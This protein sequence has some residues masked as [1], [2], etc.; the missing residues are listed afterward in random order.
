MKKFAVIAAS[1]LLLS[2][3][4]TTVTLD[5][6]PQAN[7]P[8]CAEV[9]VRLPNIVDGKAERVTSAQSTAAWGDP[10]QI[11]LRCGLPP[12]SSSTLPCV[13]SNGIDWLVDSTNAPSYRFITF[14]RTPAAEVIMDSRIAS[15][16]SVL[17]ELSSS[18][19]YLPS[20]TTCSN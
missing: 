3:C 17:D 16:A 2:G 19:S 6:A 7:D 14:G 1:T 11:I 9:I 18:V 15:S 8:K 12:A 13:T 20:S 10:A 5:A 4:T